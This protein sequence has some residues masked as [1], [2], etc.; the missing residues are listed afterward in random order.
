MAREKS[1]KVRLTDE[2]FGQVAVYAK[3]K[4]ISISEVIRD[5]IKQ[6]PKTDSLRSVFIL[7]AIHLTANPVDVAGVLSL[8]PR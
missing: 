5:Y 2:E 1:I 3:S 8:H 7:V 6:L 4:G